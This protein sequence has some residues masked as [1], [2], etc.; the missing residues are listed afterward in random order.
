MKLLFTI[1]NGIINFEKSLHQLSL[2]SSDIFAASLEVRSIG[3][4]TQITRV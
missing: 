2:W 4:L 1:K 3:N